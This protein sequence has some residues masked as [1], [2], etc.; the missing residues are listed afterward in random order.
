MT[1]EEW[2][3]DQCNRYLNGQCATLSCLRRGGYDRDVEVKPDFDRATCH[4]HEVLKALES[5][6]VTP[7]PVSVWLPIVQGE[8]TFPCVY[9]RPFLDQTLWVLYANPRLTDSTWTHWH[10][11]SP[12]PQQLAPNEKAWAEYCRKHGIQCPD[13]RAQAAV[14]FTFLAGR[15]SVRETTKRS[16][17]ETMT[18]HLNMTTTNQ[19]EPS[20]NIPNQKL[21]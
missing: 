4:P 3:R 7:T 16:R 9:G 11:L 21:V 2:L 20:E 14:K 5:H 8:V 1:N 19:I 12:F 17:N 15:A 18:R 10:P 13:S 6:A